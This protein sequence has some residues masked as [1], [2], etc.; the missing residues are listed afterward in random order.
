MIAKFN[1][2]QKRVVNPIVLYR[3]KKEKEKRKL[4]ASTI[5]YTIGILSTILVVLYLIR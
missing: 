3:K 5:L 1:N 2:E 4:I